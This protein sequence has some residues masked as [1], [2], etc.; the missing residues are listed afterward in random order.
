MHISSRFCGGA[1]GTSRVLAHHPI[2]SLVS[3]L[4]MDTA[5]R[6]VYEP[7]CFSSPA[8][9][10]E[11]TNRGA[12]TAPAVLSHAHSHNLAASPAQAQ[13][14]WSD[15]ASW[16]EPPGFPACGQDARPCTVGLR[17]PFCSHF[18]PCG[19]RTQPS[20]QRWPGIRAPWPHVQ[21][22]LQPR[23]RP[24][25]GS[26]ALSATSLRRLCTQGAWDQPGRRSARASGSPD[27]DITRCVTRVQTPSRTWRRGRQSRLPLRRGSCTSLRTAGWAPAGSWGVLRVGLWSGALGVGPW[28]WALGVAS[29]RWGPGPQGQQGPP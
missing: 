6:R 21:H 13:Q 28:G 19:Q 11:G 25:G 3:K 22:G 5:G 4:P 27:S 15:S 17:C 1:A 26:G 9:G 7:W 8:R 23:P 10:A 2:L 14:V 12:Q 16:A 24:A 29:W 18:P 20:F